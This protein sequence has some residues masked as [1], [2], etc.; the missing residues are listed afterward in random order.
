MSDT[1]KRRRLRREQADPE[2]LARMFEIP[3]ESA[4]HLILANGPVSPD[5]ALLDQAAEALHLMARAE[6]A[7]ETYFEIL[8]RPRPKQSSLASFFGGVDPHEAQIRAKADIHWEESRAL[9]QRAKT[10]MRALAKHQ[11]QTAA[12]IYAKALV[13]RGSRTGAEALAHFLARD[14][15]ALPALRAS[16]WPTEAAR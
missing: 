4:E 7:K 10:L 11:A 2:A 12:G 3:R 8:R 14:L 13:V 1:I 15:A 9:M 16:L 5:A 6:Q